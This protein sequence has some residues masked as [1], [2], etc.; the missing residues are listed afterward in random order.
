MTYTAPV[1][2]YTFPNS[3]QEGQN[4]SECIAVF[5]LRNRKDVV[6]ILHDLEDSFYDEGG[7][8]TVPAGRVD[9]IEVRL[10]CDDCIANC[11]DTE[12]LIEWY[13]F[14]P[15]DVIDVT[16]EDVF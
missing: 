12:S 16:V 14:D 3:Y 10:I 9:Y 2:G 15:E 4:D 13:G 7:W 1:S 11:F 5:T 8:C 6:E